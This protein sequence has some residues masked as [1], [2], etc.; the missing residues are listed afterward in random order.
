MCGEAALI[1][2]GSD[3]DY[4]F[5][6]KKVKWHL[7]NVIDWPTAE[8]LEPGPRIDYGFDQFRAVKQGQSDGGK[9]RRRRLVRSHQD[10]HRTVFTACWKFN[11]STVAYAR[12]NDT[13]RR[14]SH[15]VA[16][17]NFPSLVGS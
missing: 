3:A 11:L 9:G 15:A 1:T 14:L 13:F 10:K 17:E 6:V 2:Y 7:E 12:R 4:A 8:S 5:E 16:K